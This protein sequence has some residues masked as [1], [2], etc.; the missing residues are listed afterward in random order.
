V[1]IPIVFPFV[2]YFIVFSD[3]RENPR[4]V[5]SGHLH[6]YVSDEGRQSGIKKKRRPRQ[7]Q[8]E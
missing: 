3:D 5:V 7:S 6:K 4:I 8:W 1:I 2:G